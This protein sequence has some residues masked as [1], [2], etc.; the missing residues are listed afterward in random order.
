MRQWLPFLAIA[1]ILGSCGGEISETTQALK[2]VEQMSEA[3]S[4][5]QAATDKYEQRRKERI[6]NGDTIAMPYKDLQVFLPAS[7]SGYTAGE[8]SGETV[9]M[10]GMSTSTASRDY[11]KG[12][13]NV[14][15]EIMDFNGASGLWIGATAVFKANLSMEDDNQKSGTFQTGNERISGWEEYQKQGKDAKVMYMVGDRFMVTVSATNQ[16]STEFCKSIGKS[17]DLAKLAG[18]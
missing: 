8:P 13:D 1:I 3:A 10:P 12:N 17:I 6:K 15:V 9:N 7:I 18:L 2:N 11:T 5:I 4:D 14:S 16:S